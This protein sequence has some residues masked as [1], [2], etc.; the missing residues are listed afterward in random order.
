[1]FDG[2]NEERANGK[3]RCVTSLFLESG[4]PAGV[5]YMSDSEELRKLVSMSTEPEGR[6][7]T[8]AEVSFI[9]LIA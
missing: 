9:G 6:L 1:M 4:V 5:I 2:V 8:L 3:I 7:N